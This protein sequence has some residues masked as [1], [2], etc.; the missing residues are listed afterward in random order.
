MQRS[1]ASIPRRCSLVYAFPTHFPIFLVFFSHQFC[2]FYSL[3]LTL[4]HRFPC[5]SPPAPPPPL[6]LSSAALVCIK[7]HA[8][9]SLPS[10]LVE[11][12]FGH[13]PKIAL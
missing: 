10:L 6:S 12:L 2:P 9:P 8:V 11:N 5:I 3:H 7:M 13:I 4:S 1:A